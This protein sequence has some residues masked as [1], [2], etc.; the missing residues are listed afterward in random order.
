MKTEYHVFQCM[1]VLREKGFIRMMLSIKVIVCIYLEAYFHKALPCLWGCLP[2]NTFQ[3]QIGLWS[4]KGLRHGNCIGQREKDW[5][6]I[7]LLELLVEE[8]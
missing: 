5:H 8:E 1:Y 7:T 4:L 2:S 6:G 3:N